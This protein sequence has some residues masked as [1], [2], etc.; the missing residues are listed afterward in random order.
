MRVRE[1]DLGAFQ[2]AVTTAIYDD[3]PSIRAAQIVGLAPIR[4]GGHREPFDMTFVDQLRFGLD[5]GQRFV[6]LWQSG[7]AS[8]PNQV[9]RIINVGVPPSLR[10]PS[11]DPR[12]TLISRISV[13]EVTGVFVA[14]VTAEAQFTLK[15]EGELNAALAEAARLGLRTSGVIEYPAGGV[16]RTQQFDPSATGA[17]W[18]AGFRLYDDGWRLWNVR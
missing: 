4:E 6:G 12:G 14:G 1:L 13:G 8:L 9:W 5:H 17:T 10:H 3:D 7:T 2:E 16:R 18:T 11:L 15:A